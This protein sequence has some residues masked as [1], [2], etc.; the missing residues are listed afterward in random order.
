MVRLFK[1]SNEESSSSATEN[2]SNGKES[3]STKMKSA[4]CCGG[5]SHAVKDPKLIQHSQSR[6]SRGSIE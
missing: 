3:W 6:R 1:K 5:S 4:F 2:N